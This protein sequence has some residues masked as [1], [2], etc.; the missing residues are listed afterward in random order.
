MP[1]PAAKA[2]D[3]KVEETTTVLAALQKHL[4]QGPGRAARL[5]QLRR[6]TAAMKTLLAG[7][8]GG[9]GELAV[10][11]EKEGCPANAKRF[12]KL[13]LDDTLRA[14]LEGKRLLEFPTLHVAV[15]P[16]DAHVFPEPE[17]L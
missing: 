14:N 17:E 10:F 7:G 11:L 8:G 6:Y 15:L 9:G 2:D 3:A 13:K 5:H 16:E 4:K 12:F 1:K